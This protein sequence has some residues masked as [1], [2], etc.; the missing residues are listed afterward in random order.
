MPDWLTARPIAHRG[1]HDAAQGIIENTATAITAAITAGYG[2]EVDLQVTAEGG[3]VVYHDDVLGRLTHRNGRVDQYTSAELKRIGF[4]NTGDRMLTLADLCQ[5]V[6][7]RA[8]LLLELK[9]RFDGDQRLAH[10]V[11]DVLS[12]YSGPAA[13]MSFDPA[14]VHM[15]QE[16]APSLRRGVVAERYTRGTADGDEMSRGSSLKSLLRAR[17]QFVAYALTDLPA[18]A[19]LL[20]RMIRLPVLTWTARSEEDHRRAALWADQ[21]IFEGFR[22]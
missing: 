6:S 11:A 16:F 10:H 15:L 3:A 21:I 13:A 20:A 9:S 4:K 18:A 8:V 2:I 17:P 12:G 5:L 7:G 1:L 22:P 14:Q 19:P